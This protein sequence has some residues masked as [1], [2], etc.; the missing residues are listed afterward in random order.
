MLTAQ[1]SSL[2]GD[3]MSWTAHYLISSKLRFLP[4]TF[5]GKKCKSNELVG[6]LTS[7]GLYFSLFLF[8]KEFFHS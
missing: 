4:V 2:V 6:L 3:I 1:A 8:P 7:Q 5:D